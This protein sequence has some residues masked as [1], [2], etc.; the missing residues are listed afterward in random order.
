MWAIN[1]S[2]EVVGVFFLPFFI[3]SPSAL[4]AGLINSFNTFSNL[5]QPLLHY[6]F[7]K[8]L[9]GQGDSRQK[10]MIMTG[11]SWTEAGR[12]ST[13][14]LLLPVNLRIEH[15]EWICARVCVWL[16]G[17]AGEKVRV[18]HTES[19]HYSLF[20]PFHSISSRLPPSPTVAC[21]LPQ[22]A[23]STRLAKGCDCARTSHIIVSGQAIVGHYQRAAD[24]S[25][26]RGAVMSHGRRLQHW[27]G[28]D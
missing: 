17:D 13:Q 7:T 3:L 28:L 22:Q 25:V 26:T 27:V 12:T 20:L 4:F 24:K 8:R 5:P 16:D 6:W 21:N 1:K 23:H 15:C 19:L 11:T 14:A 2:S 10:E 9:F 18:L